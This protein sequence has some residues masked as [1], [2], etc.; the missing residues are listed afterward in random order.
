MSFR[1]RI[2]KA[3]QKVVP[4]SSRIPE[5]AAIIDARLA[6][7]EECPELRRPIDQ[8]AAC[9]C[10]VRAKARIKGAACPLGKW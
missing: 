10:F 3:A 8:C 6:E 5:Q 9:G 1:D 7:C 4:L 2:K